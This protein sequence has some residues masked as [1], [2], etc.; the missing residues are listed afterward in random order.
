MKIIKTEAWVVEMPLKQAYTIAYETIDHASNVFL[1]LETNTGLIGYG[2]A[3]PDLQV[4]GE[5]PAGVML[6][7]ENVIAPTLANS[8]PLRSA[9]LLE[10]LK[11]TLLNQPSVLAAVDMALYDLLGKVASLPLWKLLG[12]FRDRM[13]TSV[14][15]GILPVYET[16]H[17]AEKWL[18]AGFKCLKIKGGVDVRVDIERILKLRELVGPN[19]ELRFDANQG[20]TYEESLAFVNETRSAKLELMEQPTPKGEPDLLGR[21]TDTVP[22]PVMADES[23]MTLRDAFRLAKRNLA[24]M[25]NIKLM[26]VGGIAEAMHINSV[27]RSAG[28]EV[29]VGCMDEA[30]LAIAAGLH[31][32]LA[33]PNV[34]Y[35]DLDGHF[36]LLNDPT[37]GAVLIRNGYLFP[38]NRPGLGFDF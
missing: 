5:T 25:V 35:A 27:A 26:K 2:C 29:M 33:R 12:G 21:V 37:D 3:A 36:D 28:L 11:S 24:D 32:A 34:M 15:I 14:T 30:A 4:T 22:I 7:V 18:A 9:M 1:R 20:Y 38:T 23:L 6:A 13:K 31:F 16:M 17:E 8:D 10:R 19:F